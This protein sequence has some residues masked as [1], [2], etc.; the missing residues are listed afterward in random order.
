MWRPH[1]ARGGLQAP[2]NLG[3]ILHLAAER[4]VLER[5]PRDVLRPEPVLVAGRRA[6]VAARRGGPAHARVE[7]D[8]L[9]LVVPL[10][11]ERRVE[12]RAGGDVEPLHAIFSDP[13]ANS[14]PEP[15]EW[16]AV[17]S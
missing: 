17:S 1:H 7:R 6:G 13:R 12:P 16:K 10:R 2:A 5:Q 8:A 4:Q 9:R 3:L 14:E 15:T 11:E